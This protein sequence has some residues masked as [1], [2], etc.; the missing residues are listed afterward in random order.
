M[1]N[2]RRQLDVLMLSERPLWPVD[3]G[4]RIRGY[5]MAQALR[6]LGVRVGI[7]CIERTPDTAPEQLRDIILPWPQAGEEAREIMKASWRGPLSP[8]RRRVARYLTPSLEVLAGATQLALDHQPRIAIGMG[9]H[10]PILLRGLRKMKRIRS[11][12]YAADE[13]VRFHLSCMWQD[14]LPDVPGRLRMLIV[15]ALLERCFARTLDGSIGVSPLEARWLGRIVTPGRSVTIRNGV[16]LERFRPPHHPP[17]DRTAIFWG[18]MDFEPNIEACLWFA[19]RVWP[20]LQR[21]SPGAVWRIVGKNPVD[22]VQELSRIRGI[23]VVGEVPDIQQEAKNA[24]VTILPMRSGGGIKNKLL[25]AAAMGRPIIAS[26]RAV[27]GLNLPDRDE[28]LMICK[29][30]RSWAWAI[31]KLW[32]DINTA[33][34]LGR[35]ARKWVE[36]HHSW[37]NAAWRLLEWLDTVDR[38]APR[39]DNWRIEAPASVDHPPDEREYLLQRLFIERR[40][41]DDHYAYG[42]EAA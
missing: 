28:P 35:H 8:I 16:D 22:R 30:A 6:Q 10:G 39:D 32:A 33:D 37:P 23:E 24:A 4:Y 1:A 9:Q 29:G 31:Q 38:D 7:G 11:I 27:Q 17:H 5:H 2:E 25:E 12:W 18:R 15:H 21:Y 42:K 19:H 36:T 34:R 40:H 20:L 13:L 14:P 41:R 26:P 3:Q